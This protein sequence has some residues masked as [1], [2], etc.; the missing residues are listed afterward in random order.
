MSNNILRINT[1]YSNRFQRGRRYYS[2][3]PIP[4]GRRVS[5][6]IVLSIYEDNRESEL[7]SQDYVHSEPSL[8]ANFAYNMGEEEIVGQISELVHDMEGRSWSTTGFHSVTSLGNDSDNDEDESADD[9]NH[10][11]GEAFRSLREM[12]ATV[13][14]LNRSTTSS[15]QDPPPHPRS[16]ISQPVRSP[17]S[18]PQPT[19]NLSSMPPLR[20]PRMSVAERIQQSVQRFRQS[21]ERSTLP[22]SRDS[23]SEEEDES[24]IVSSQVRSNTPPTVYS[25]TTEIRDLMMCKICYNHLVTSIAFPCFHVYCG[26]CIERLTECAFCRKRIVNANKINF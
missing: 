20:R 4:I 21:A 15:V 14:I 7:L 18:S 5:G 23:S 9:E 22:T 25:E 19:D 11:V 10:P 3:A 2:I 13:G 8:H 12:Y 26:E 1:R 16:P 6:R 17:P 24:T